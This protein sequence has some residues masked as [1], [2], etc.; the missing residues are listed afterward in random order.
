MF[1]K[2]EKYYLLNG[3]RGVLPISSVTFQIGIGKGRQIFLLKPH[4]FKGNNQLN[5]ATK[6]LAFADTTYLFYSQ[7]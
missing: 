7:L 1:L 3:W 4:V 6:L 5:A 2:K